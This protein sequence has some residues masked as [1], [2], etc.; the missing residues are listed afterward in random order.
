MYIVYLS[1]FF[2]YAAFVGRCHSLI[3]YIF[4]RN[5]S[6]MQNHFGVSGSNEWNVSSSMVKYTGTPCTLRFSNVF[7]KI[8]PRG[9]LEKT[10]PACRQAGIV[11]EVGNYIFCIVIFNCGI[12]ACTVFQRITTSTPKYSWIALF[13]APTIRFH[14]IS[15]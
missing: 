13:R 11:R 12:S 14:G 4:Y 3:V 7:S 2:A 10:G 15:G 1:S 6:T 8:L 9:L 5:V